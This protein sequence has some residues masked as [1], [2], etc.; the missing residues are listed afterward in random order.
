MIL[1]GIGANL[2]SGAGGSPAV[3]CRAALGSLA[4]RGVVVAAC[5]RWFESA[6]V[7]PSAQPWYVNGVARVTTELEPDALLELLHRVED[8]YGRRRGAP[9]AARTLDLDLIAYDEMVRAGPDGPVLPHPR[10]H[11]RLF[12][13]LPLLEVAPD[14]RHPVLGRTA[15]RLLAELPP[16]Q[17]ARPLEGPQE[18]RPD[19]A[20]GGASLR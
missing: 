2:P 14:W 1:I 8:E 4:G 3:T 7:P 17:V 18:G 11:Q 19:R 20:S 9:N 6:P 15:A 12:V 16:G 5:S 10:L 13:L